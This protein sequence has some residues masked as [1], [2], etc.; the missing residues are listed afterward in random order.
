MHLVHSVS[1]RLPRQNPIDSWNN[2]VLNERLMYC[3]NKKSRRK[4]TGE[5]EK[6]EADHLKNEC[7]YAQV[8]CS[9]CQRTNV[10]CVPCNEK[11]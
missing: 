11:S 6:F 5:L 7:L 8:L 9:Q 3:L 2:Y 1:K 10:T 4:L